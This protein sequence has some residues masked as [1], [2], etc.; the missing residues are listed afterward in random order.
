M[1]SQI[2]LQILLWRIQ[3]EIISIEI[4]L[5]PKIEGLHF[6]RVKVPDDI[7]CFFLPSNV[8]IQGVKN[9]Y[10]FQYYAFM[11]CRN[12]HHSLVLASL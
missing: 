7:K 3:H 10:S 6:L 5:Y 8:F 12:Q 9:L 11:I 2:H 4:T 1:V